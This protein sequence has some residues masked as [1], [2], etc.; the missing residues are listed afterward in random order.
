MRLAAG[1][2]VAALTLAANHGASAYNGDPDYYNVEPPIT[3]ELDL[4]GGPGG[5]SSPT[6]TG[7]EGISQNNVRTI[8]G[9]F[10]EIPPDT[11]GAVGTT[12]FMQTSNGAYAIYDKSSHALISMVADGTFWKNA[13]QPYATGS[14][15]NGDSRVLFDN[16]SK[17][18][19]VESFAANVEDIQIAVSDTSDATGG[20]KSTTFHVFDDGHGH[21]LADYPTLAMDSKAVYIGTND[22]SLT[23]TSTLNGCVN[24]IQ[25]CGTTLSVISRNDIFNASGPQTASLQQFVTTLTSGVD[26]GFAIQGVNQVNGS[27]AGQ[28]TAV[29]AYGPGLIRYD[30]TSPGSGSG[31]QTPVTFLDPTPYDAN[32]LAAQPDG[33]RLVDTLDDRVSSAVWEFNGKIYAVHTITPVGGDHSE[34]QWYVIDAATNTVVQEGIIGD[35]VHDFFQGTIG[36]NSKGQVMISYNRSGFG[37]DGNVTIFAQQFNQILGGNGAIT[38][39]GGPIVLH[40]SPIDNY[41]NGTISSVLPDPTKTRQRW[42]DMAQ[43]TVD[44]NNPDSFWIIGEFARPYDSPT[45][46]SRWGTWISNIISVPEPSTW[47]MMILGMG[48]IGAMA[49]RRRISAA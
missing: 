3:P 6:V 43:I 17:R 40:V 46:G 44:P 37:A 18:W 1:V 31:T 2:A 30:V 41:H 26:R 28:I 5:P 19:V 23:G 49:R 47:A 21:G 20:W 8:H 10:S 29:S 24:G 4:F 45:S 12:Q 35:G 33:S 25:Y 34:V 38:A 9:G 42:G 36:V 15:S 16:V 48:A 27:N 32:N 22:F 7:F 14:F 13:G 11:M 39:A